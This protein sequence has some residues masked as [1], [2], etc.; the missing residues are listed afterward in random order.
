MESGIS[1]KVALVTG[2]SMG[3]GKATAMGLASHG[4]KIAI[5]ARNMDRLKQAAREI[6]DETGATVIP[7]SADTTSSEDITMLVWST[8]SELGHIDILVNNAVNSTTARAS[9]LP[10]DI[11]FNHINIT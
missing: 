1:G 10:D 6:Q 11:I 9:E 2:G 4:A 5:C 3:I 7:I 8:I